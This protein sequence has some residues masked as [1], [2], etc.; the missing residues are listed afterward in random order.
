MGSLKLSCYDINS[1][2]DQK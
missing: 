1:Q 2:H